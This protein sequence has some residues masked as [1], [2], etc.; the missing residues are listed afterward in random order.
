MSV[1]EQSG[2]GA[3]EENEGKQVPLQLLGE[4]EA[5]IKDVAHD[6][7]YEN[8]RDDD[9]RS[10]GDTSPHP[11]VYGVDPSAK[12]A[13][14]DRHWLSDELYLKEKYCQAN[15]QSET[16]IREAHPFMQDRNFIPL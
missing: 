6:H 11:F 4:H 3:H 1:L 15:P 9:R 14:K 7:V 16:M 12:V 5:G 8:H 10:P 2:S 13:E